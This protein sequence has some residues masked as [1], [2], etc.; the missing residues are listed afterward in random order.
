MRELPDP[1][2][3]EKR[4]AAVAAAALVADGMRVGL[5]TGSTVAHFVTALAA[6]ACDVRC[7]ATSPAT[8][9]A[10]T[11]LGLRVEPFDAFDA[12]DLAVD[13]ADQVAPDGWLVKGAGGAH[14]REKVVA[15]SASSFVVIVD[16]SKPVERLAPPVPL[17]LMAFGLASTL[18]HLGDAVV[19]DAPRTPDGG[20]LADYHGVFTDPAALAGW[21]SSVPG[22]VGHGLFEPDL[23]T[24]VLVGRGDSVT[25]VS[26]GG[27]T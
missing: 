14:T 2:V 27:T 19:R 21:L 9:S 20:V 26:F 10:A 7:V 11:A 23:V 16:S 5:G 18:R 4:V 6:R 3:G 12:L 24:K 22:V 13:G 8:A 17:E 25:S 1:A 15:T